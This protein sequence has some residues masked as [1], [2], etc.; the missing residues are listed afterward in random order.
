MTEQQKKAI[1]RYREDFADNCKK[2]IAWGSQRDCKFN[3]FQGTKQ[4]DS[5]YTMVITTIT[6]LSD[7]LQPYVETVNLMVEPDGNVL[8]LSDVFE[9]SQVVNYVEQLKK[10]E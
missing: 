5:N 1:E 8:N 6:G 4:D 2:F 9:P 3:L 7:D 10:I